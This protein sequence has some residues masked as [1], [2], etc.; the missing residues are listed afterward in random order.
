MWGGM[1]ATAS[2]SEFH[3]MPIVWEYTHAAGMD[4]AYWSAQHMFF[5]NSGTWLEA[6]PWTRH[7]VGATKLEPDATYETGADD[8]KLVDY[9][10]PRSA[11]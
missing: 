8:G 5:A 9:A 4:T 6:T 7:F 11:R 3:T 2:R 1:A 10:H